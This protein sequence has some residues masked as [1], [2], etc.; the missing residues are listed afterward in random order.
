MGIRV[1][2]GIAALL[3]GTLV[4]G[5]GSAAGDA[6]VR[7]SDRQAVIDAFYDTWL[8]NQ[9]VP[10]AWTGSVEQCSPGETSEAAVA[11]TRRQINYFR[12]LAGLR[13]VTFDDGMART[14][15]RTALIMDANDRLSHDPPTW[16]RC[17]TRSGS[18]LA[19]RS[20][21]AL[22]TEGTGPRAITRY[23]QDTGH[24]SVAHRRWVL[25]PRTAQ[26]A[27]GS[28]AAASALVVVGMPEHSRA[29]PDWSPWPPAGYF[30]APLEP[31]GV[32]S[33]STTL[34]RVDL[35]GARVRVTDGAG[36]RYA[37]KTLPLAAAGGPPTLVWTVN[38]LRTPSLRRD[39]SYQV[40]VS[41]LERGGAPMKR[42]GW[43]VTLVRP[44]RHVAVVDR[45]VLRGSFQVGSE[46]VVS[47]GTWSPAPLTWS[48]QWLRD[49]TPIAGA[50]YPFY[51]PTAS[52]EGH[53]LSVR[54]GAKATYY[55]PGTVTVH[56]AVVMP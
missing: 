18:D 22:G 30:P 8:R 7:N 15:Q 16:W 45:P 56:G 5:Q 9:K 14:A 17:H 12:T 46:L 3:T 20:N 32:W 10:I 54:V 36:R 24:T 43:T 1:G 29:V 55:A 50:T 51:W 44:D 52:D 19:S 28:T 2:C 48:H 4:L 33:L 53:L 13:R 35:S 41:G 6:M 11:A 25:N 23:I 49:G 42:L 21:L 31:D 34:A 40:R 39:I 38:D 47:P 37:V 26:M 27:T